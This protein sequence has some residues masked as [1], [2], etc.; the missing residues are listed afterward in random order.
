MHSKSISLALLATGFLVSGAISQHA[1]V[2]NDDW[3][4]PL[5]IV[6]I[7]I[8]AMCLMAVYAKER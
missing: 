3:A 8:G 6:G 7:I 4:I 2:R 5:F 1:G